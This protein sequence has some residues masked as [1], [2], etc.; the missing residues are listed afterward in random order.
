MRKCAVH[1]CLGFVAIICISSFFCCQ[2]SW[3]LVSLVHCYRQNHHQCLELSSSQD[4]ACVLIPVFS[5]PLPKTEIV[6]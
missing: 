6:P 1:P 3:V 5:G 2:F 4:W